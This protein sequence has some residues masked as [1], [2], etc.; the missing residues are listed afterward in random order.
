MRPASPVPASFS[1][2]HP[3]AP[4]AATITAA[5]IHVPARL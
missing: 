1:Q 5:T 2:Y 4:A 3:P